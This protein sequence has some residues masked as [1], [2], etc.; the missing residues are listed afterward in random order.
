[1]KNKKNAKSENVNILRFKDFLLP[2]TEGVGKPIVWVTWT[3]AKIHKLRYMANNKI[4]CRGIMKVLMHNAQQN[5]FFAR[6]MHIVIFTVQT[7]KEVEE[8]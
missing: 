6:K 1:M 8:S 2:F 3:R 4:L 7:D 5:I